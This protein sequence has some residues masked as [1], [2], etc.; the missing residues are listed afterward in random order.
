MLDCT[1]DSRRGISTIAVVL[2]S[3]ALVMVVAVAL[4]SGGGGSQDEVHADT[5]LHVVMVGDFEVS[6]PASGE[7]AAHDQ[8]ELRCELDGTATITEIIDEGA[9]VEAGD[10]LVRLDDKDVMERIRSAEE[11]VVAARNQVETRTA[12]FAITQKSR[13]SSLAKSNVAVDQNKL[14]LNG[15][16]RST[17]SHWNFA[18]GTSSARTISS[19]MK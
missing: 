9:A 7:L 2:T 14:A 11:T 5:D 12:D 17:G 8:V 18:N 10:V 4:L 16:R 13:E 6:I 19:R 15:S 3:T 1:N